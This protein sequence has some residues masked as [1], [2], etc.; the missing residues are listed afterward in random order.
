VLLFF[1]V[2]QK[3]RLLSNFCQTF[4]ISVGKSDRTD[5][6]RKHWSIE[7]PCLI[8]LFTS[9]RTVLALSSLISCSRTCKTGVGS[10][11]THSSGTILVMSHLM[12]FNIK[13][14]Y[15]N[16][17]HTFLEVLELK[18]KNNKSTAKRSIPSR[19]THTHTCIY[20]YIK[21]Y[22][23]QRHEQVNCQI[24]G[25]ISSWRR[26]GSFWKFDNLLIR[27]VDHYSALYNHII[28]SCIYLID[29]TLW[30]TE[31]YWYNSAS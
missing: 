24:F 1:Y 7:N 17:S 29:P 23:D 25:T 11:W 4:I 10:I 13:E 6:F 15:L 8:S 20:T 19:Y 2:R 28:W 16:N 14:L 9:F 30:D 3:D 31:C 27:V 22:N 5:K 18:Y 12:K 21:H 26:N